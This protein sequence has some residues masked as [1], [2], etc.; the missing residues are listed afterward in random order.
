MDILSEILRNIQLSGS[1]WCRTEA[2]APWAM[3]IP[4]M[5]LAQFH[6]VRRGSCILNMAGVKEPMH[7]SSGDVIFFPHGQ[8]H[9]LSDN[10]K[11]KP[12]PILELIS[13]N[14]SEEGDA[15]TIGGNGAPT[16]LICGKCHF[17]HSEVHPLLSLLPP[18]I[19]VKG[20]DE[21]TN[22]WLETTLDFIS[23]ETRSGNQGSQT[24]ITRLV[25]IL[26]IQIIRLHIAGLHE[27]EKGWLRGL[28]DQQISRALGYIHSQP[29]N[30]WTIDSL[31]AAVGM[32]RAS[33]AA[34]FK[35]LVGESPFQYLTRWRMYK[36][37]SY[38]KTPHA[39]VADVAERVGY[40][41][42]AAFSKVFKRHLGV[43]PGSYRRRLMQ[44]DNSQTIQ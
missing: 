4:T 23:S 3:K 31:A 13:I 9:T 39:A 22:P 33:F 32:S 21:R 27:N 14:K 18:V 37:T 34:R 10:L 11:T 6:V 7:L 26:F 15:L 41:T 5:D 30:Q 35:Q 42:E 2:A 1:L 8:E 25:E 44:E 19:H 43:A 28:Q 29:E 24:V 40:Q 36:A 12:V 17:D 20:E 38:L 16:T